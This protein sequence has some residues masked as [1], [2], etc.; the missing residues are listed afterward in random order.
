MANVFW[1]RVIN[2]VYIK[3]DIR[4]TPQIYHKLSYEQFLLHEN[5]GYVN[6]FAG[7][8]Q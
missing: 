1:L 7:S 5:V 4:N 3:L 8:L 6:V 2:A